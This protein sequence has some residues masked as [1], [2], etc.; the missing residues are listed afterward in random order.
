MDK[1]FDI[2]KLTLA[3]LN[4]AN[5]ISNQSIKKLFDYF[6]TA[7]SMWYNLKKETGALTFLSPDIKK[8]LCDVQDGFEEKLR[9]KLVQENVFIVTM[10]DDDYPAKLKHIEGTPYILYCKGD[11]KAVND[12]SIAVVGSRKA[13]AYGKWA[14]D[15]LTGELADYGITIISGLATGIDSI[16]HRAAIEHGAL[17]V[18]VIGC[19]IDIVYP[20]K[21]EALYNEIINRGGAV[22]TEYPFGMEPMPGNFPARN[23]IISGLSDGVLVIEA[24]EKSGTLITAGHAAD[25]GKDVYAVPGNINSLFSRGTNKLI[26]D[27]AKLVMTVDDIFEENIGLKNLIREKKYSGFDTNNLSDP[28]LMVLK[29]LKSGS[30]TIDEISQE[31]NM[32]TGA[33]LATMTLLE[34]KGLIKRV[35]SDSFA[36]S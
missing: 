22:I 12:I 20:K 30:N 11:I 5:G 15:K 2:Y 7:S 28:E 17:T 35:S 9:K 14:A 29:A 19:G 32:N 10:F 6:G 18:G 33:I 1:I 16:A 34:M 27:G 36:L 24:Q 13:T 26:Q 25:Q 8:Y 21:N 3:W 23:R 4:S 31:T